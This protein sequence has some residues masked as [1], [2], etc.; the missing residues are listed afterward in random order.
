MG[1]RDVQLVWDEAR[2]SQSL[3]CWVLGV[4]SMEIWGFGLVHQWF[5]GF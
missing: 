2:V 3:E 5:D 4:A 1:N